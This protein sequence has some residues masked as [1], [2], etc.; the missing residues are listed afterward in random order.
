MTSAIF[1]VT[2]ALQRLPVFFVTHHTPDD[3]SHDN[4]QNGQNDHCSHVNTSVITLQPKTS[5][6]PLAAP[7]FAVYNIL[8]RSCD[9]LYINL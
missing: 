1:A 7:N 4:D 3:Q 2:A 8:L 6:E 5:Y 9:F